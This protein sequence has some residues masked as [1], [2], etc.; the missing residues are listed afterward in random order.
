[1]PAADERCGRHERL[2]DLS[3]CLT[4]L[5]LDDTLI[6]VIEMSRSSW[7]LAGIVPCVERQ[8]LKK[9]ALNESTLPMLLQAPFIRFSLFCSCLRPVTSPLAVDP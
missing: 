9:L 4:P 5:I 3:R 8:P 6:A 2:N 1:M 7:L